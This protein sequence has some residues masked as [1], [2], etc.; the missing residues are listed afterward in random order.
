MRTGTHKSR[1]YYATYLN[2]PQEIRRSMGLSE[3]MMIFL[4]IIKLGR[5][6]RISVMKNRT[7]LDN[8]C[9]KLVETVT[10]KYKNREYT[11]IR[12]VIPQNLSEILKLD[13]NSEAEFTQS[14]NSF[15]ID[16]KHKIY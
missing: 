8:A 1:E 5:Y 10:R 4:G 3:G 6:S 14:G 12:L 7:H 9:V 2:I 15:F 16:F 13:R 11:V